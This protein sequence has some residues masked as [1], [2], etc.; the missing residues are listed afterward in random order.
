MKIKAL[1]FTAI[2]LVAGI[3]LGIWCFYTPT[4]KHQDSYTYLINSESEKIE[5][6][7]WDNERYL[8]RPGQAWVRMSDGLV[9]SDLWRL[10]DDLANACQYLSLKAADEALQKGCNGK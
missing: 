6:L 1:G 4:P 2:G 5:Q 7:W 9:V 8:R 10:H 3:S